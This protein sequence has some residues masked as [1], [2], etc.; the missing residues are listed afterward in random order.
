M[1]PRSAT[2]LL[3]FL[4]GTTAL[5]QTPPVVPGNRHTAHAPALT[6][7]EARAARAFNAAKALGAPELYAF[8]RPMPKAATSIC[9]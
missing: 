8:L 2:V 1:P 9:T 4:L 5:A 3:A 6:P 7:G